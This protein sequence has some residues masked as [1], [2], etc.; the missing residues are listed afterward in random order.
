MKSDTSCLC[1]NNYLLHRL[2]AIAAK[3]GRQ[4]LILEVSS[5]ITVGLNTKCSVVASD[6]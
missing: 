5:M 3:L 4:L 2:Q 6:L 1:P